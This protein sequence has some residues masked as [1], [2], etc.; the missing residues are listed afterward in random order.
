MYCLSGDCGSSCFSFS[1]FINMSPAELHAVMVVGLYARF[2]L[3]IT[4]VSTVRIAPS[5]TTTAQL[6]IDFFDE[7]DVGLLVTRATLC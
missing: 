6:V 7:S 1:R 3:Q 2:V 5:V 4:L